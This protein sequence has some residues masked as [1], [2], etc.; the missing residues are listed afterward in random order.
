M[1]L[2][3]DYCR[4][5]SGC[6]KSCILNVSVAFLIWVWEWYSSED[7]PVANKNKAPSRYGAVPSTKTYRRETELVD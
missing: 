4:Q 5:V 2:L 3:R 7:S 6:C 1:L